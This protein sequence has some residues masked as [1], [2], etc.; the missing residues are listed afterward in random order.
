[1]LRYSDNIRGE[2]VFKRNPEMFTQDKSFSA[3][4]FNGKGELF[5][6]RI[7]GVWHESIMSVDRCFG[8]MKSRWR[9]LKI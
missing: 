5:F 7:D 6:K 9:K 4:I 1:M 8:V 2:E 3:I